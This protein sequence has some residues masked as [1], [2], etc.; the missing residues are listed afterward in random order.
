MRSGLCAYLDQAAKKEKIQAERQ[1]YLYF[2]KSKR[3]ATVVRQLLYLKQKIQ[4]LVGKDE[5]SDL[6]LSE[7]EQHDILVELRNIFDENEINPDSK[8]IPSKAKPW[9]NE[10]LFSKVASFIDLHCGQRFPVLDEDNIVDFL[11][12]T[13]EYN[14]RLLQCMAKGK[15]VDEVKLVY[16]EEFE[17]E[18]KGRMREQQLHGWSHAK[19]DA[20]IRGDIEALKDLS[21]AKSRE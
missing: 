8:H 4:E 9:A 2:C 7:S 14:R 20:L 11:V 1:D 17:D 21:R 5:L 3:N 13:K 16:T 10:E 18:H 12:K 6:D 15:T 19:K